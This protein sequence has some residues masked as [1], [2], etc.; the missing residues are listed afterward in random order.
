VPYEAECYIALST[1]SLVG[2]V[3]RPNLLLYALIILTIGLFAFSFVF[4]DPEPTSATPTGRQLV[5]LFLSGTLLYLARTMFRGR[6][7][8]QPLQRC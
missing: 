6:A 2:I 4:G 1:L 3:K 7:G 8:S 5:L